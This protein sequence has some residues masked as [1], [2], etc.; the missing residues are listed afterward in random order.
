MGIF[1][2]HYSD[3]LLAKEI[4]KAY[5]RLVAFFLKHFKIGGLCRAYSS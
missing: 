4:L 1:L 2:F 5:S 3:Y